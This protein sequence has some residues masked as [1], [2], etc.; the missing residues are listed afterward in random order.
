MKKVF[1]TM[2]LA[3]ATMIASAQFMVV[4]NINQPSDNTEWGVSNFTD[5]IGIGYKIDDNTTLGVMKNG[6]DYDLWGRYQMEWAYLSFQA[7]TEDMVDNMN[8]GIGYSLSVWDGL[9]IEPNYSM[10]LKEDED[11]NREGSFKLGL[12]YKF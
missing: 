11:G 3:F 8:I 5:N 9:N 1:L 4:T 7:P 6:E 10:P 2:T 12:S